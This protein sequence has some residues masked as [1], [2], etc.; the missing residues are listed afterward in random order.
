MTQRP[1]PSVSQDSEQNVD[2]DMLICPPEKIFDLAVFEETFRQKTHQPGNLKEK[3]AILVAELNR[4]N[5]LS[6]ETLKAAFKENP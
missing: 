4:L 6:R 1:K 5:E 2:A 3:K